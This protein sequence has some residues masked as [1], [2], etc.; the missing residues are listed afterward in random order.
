MTSITEQKFREKLI[1]EATK[2]L[3]ITV[4]H[5][6]QNSWDRRHK[7]STIPPALGKEEEIKQEPI[8][9]IQ[10]GND[11]KHQ[12]ETIGI[13]RTTTLDTQTQLSD[14]NGKM[15]QLPEKCQFARVCRGKSHSNTRK[16]N[17]LEDM[18]SEEDNN[19]GTAKVGAISKA[20]NLK[21]GPFG[22]CETPAGCKKF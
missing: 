6:T 12:F 4:E 9:R 2:N 11:V 13:L 21:G 20:Q 18:T 14:K 8:Q 5:I 19:P 1:R 7:Q 16:I 17:Y 22:L 15:Q 10:T 3:K